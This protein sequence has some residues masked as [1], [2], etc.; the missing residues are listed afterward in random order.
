MTYRLRDVFT[1]YP[2]GEV[3][4]LVRSQAPSTSGE[5]P[6]AL[7]GERAGDAV[8]ALEV[9]K[10]Q[11]QRRARR[12]VDEIEVLRRPKPAPDAALLG[13]LLARPVSTAGGSM[14]VNPTWTWR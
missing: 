3:E 5:L 12:I 7:A 13:E 8:L 14:V 10:L 1:R 4:A 11:R 2:P 9:V 6:P